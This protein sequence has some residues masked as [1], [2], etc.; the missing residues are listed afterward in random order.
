M[1]EMFEDGSADLFVSG[2]SG[3]QVRGC[4]SG[5][6]HQIPEG[7]GTKFVILLHQKAGP[8]P[9]VIKEPVELPVHLVGVGNFSVR[10]L[11][12]LHHIDDLTQDS[13]EGDDRII[14][15]H[16]GEPTTSFP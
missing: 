12:I 10:L 15:W 5:D 4:S 2:A 9:E 16:V 1:V 7:G 6:T 11:D 8:A 14:W 3:P 13:V